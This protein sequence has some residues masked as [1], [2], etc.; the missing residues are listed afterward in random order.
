MILSSACQR[1]ADPFPAL[2]GGHGER[3]SYTTLRDTIHKTLHNRFRRWTELSVFDRIF[4]N[5][6]A[7]DGPPGTLM[8]DATHLKAHRTGSSLIKGGFFSNTLAGKR[9]D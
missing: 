4:S 8:V 5:L 2:A 9:V 3:R 7:S 6:A 1:Q